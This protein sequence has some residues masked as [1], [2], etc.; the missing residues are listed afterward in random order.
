MTPQQAIMVPDLSSDPFGEL[1]PQPFETEVQVLGGRFYFESNS[2]RLLRLVDAAYAGLPAHR[3]SRP[4]PK[5]RVK[6]ALTLPL[7]SGSRAKPPRLSMLSATGLLGGSTA[8][9]NFVLI[10]AA[11]RSALVVVSPQMLRHGYNTR[12]ELIEFAVFTLAARAQKLVSLHAACVGHAGRGVLLMGPSGAGKS[13]VA[14]QCLS[15]GLDFLSEDAVFVEPKTM[16]ATGCA[17]F[18]HVRA[19]SLRWLERTDAAT[20]LKS[21]MIQRRSG[22]K[23]FEVNLRQGS[24]RLASSPLEIVAIVFLSAQ[25]AAPGVLLRRVR[26]SELRAHLT[27][28]QAY[29]A[30]RPEWPSFAKRAA[31]IDAFELCRGL[32]PREAAEALQTLLR[33]QTRLR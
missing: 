28:D 16:R 3:L 2:R 1:S 9:S 17:N 26:K 25:S 29:A 20:I 6:L 14:L 10:C 8:D 21:P 11:E 15:L 13:T 5:F 18:L 31:S 22:V 27:A 23:K 19:D 32:H 30:S 24:Y 33:I 7:R 12:Y 4:G